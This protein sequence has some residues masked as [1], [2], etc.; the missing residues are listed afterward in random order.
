MS[1]RSELEEGFVCICSFQRN[2]REGGVFEIYLKKSN[3]TCDD[4]VTVVNDAIEQATIPPCLE[5]RLGFILSNRQH[6]LKNIIQSTEIKREHLIACNYLIREDHTIRVAN[7]DEDQVLQSG[8]NT[9][10]F[11]SIMEGS[12][13]RMVMA[14][15]RAR[16][17]HR[18]LLVLY[19]QLFSFRLI[20]Q[21]FYISLYKFSN[22][23]RFSNYYEVNLRDLTGTPIENISLKKVFEV[24]QVYNSIDTNNTIDGTIP[25]LVNLN[26]GGRVCQFMLSRYLVT[27]M[28]PD[29]SVSIQK[30]QLLVSMPRRNH[31]RNQRPIYTG[32]DYSMMV[33]NITYDQAGVLTEPRIAAFILE[34]LNARA[35]YQPFNAHIWHL[36]HEKTQHSIIELI[37]LTQIAESNHG[38]DYDK[39]RTLGMNKLARRQFA[40]ISKGD[41]TFRESFDSSTADRYYPPIRDGGTRRARNAVSKV[42]RAGAFCHD[43]SDDSD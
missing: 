6:L 5:G 35:V 8:F 21:E 24:L 11:R 31:T 4:L 34:I 28:Y 41:I 13:A 19:H 33:N 38:R 22:L 27:E 25:I 23:H 37:A 9:R 17:R 1:I 14:Y 20:N 42:Q 2:P 12:Y 10:T 43:M 32:L 3:K 39:S 36:M 30:N 15:Q 40:A 7:A 29:R 26:M 18:D 16:D